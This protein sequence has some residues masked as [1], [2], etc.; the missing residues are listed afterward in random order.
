MSSDAPAP[1]AAAPA[2]NRKSVYTLMLINFVDLMGFG[3]VVLLLPFYAA[4]FNASTFTIGA[5][6]A[7]FSLCQFIGAPILGAWSDRVGRR[8]VL[9]FSQWGSVVGYLLLS[10]SM[11]YPWSSPALGLTVMFVS[12][13]I[14]GFTAGNLTVTNA[15][16]ADVIPP[17]DRA[18]IN[19]LLGAAFGLGF[20][21]GP[22]IGGLL[23]DKHPALPGLIA[24]FMSGLASVLVW[25]TLPESHND[26]TKTQAG[27]F[28]FSRDRIAAV[29]GQST[30]LALT[31]TWFLSMLAYVMLEPTVPLLLKSEFNYGERE[32]GFFFGLVG[33]VI[34][35]VQGGLIRPLNKRIGEWPLALAGSTVAAVGM[36]LYALAVHGHPSL[37]AIG[38]AAILNA[39]GR[40][41][42]TPTLSALVSQNADPKNFGAAYGVYQGVASLGRV[43][44]PLLGAALFARVPSLMFI[45]GTG[46]ITAGAI[47]LIVMRNRLKAYA[48]IKQPFEQPSVGSRPAE[49]TG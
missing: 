35:F 16:V 1:D 22:P 31:A 18:G 12:R 19:G 47:I 2:V 49:S 6:L 10:L 20:A 25:K 14:D 30:V 44:G 11:W 40:S 17:K 46:L 8:P 5:L 27:R 13:I 3:L 41:L 28:A 9:I 48:P 36:L 38:I 34:I 7:T 24:A 4:K 39:T 26:R 42:Q 21:F 43:L 45:V 37:V 32:A 33:C 29:S 15:Y 23:G